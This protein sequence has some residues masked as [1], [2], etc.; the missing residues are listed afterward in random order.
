VGGR[1]AGEVVTRWLSGNRL[2][3]FMRL[4]TAAVV[5]PVPAP[6]R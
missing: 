6:A 3:E 2:N 5:A 4:V 1:H